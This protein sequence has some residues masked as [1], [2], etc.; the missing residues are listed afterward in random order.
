MIL[1]VK[2][3]FTKPLFFNRTLINIKATFSQE[4]RFELIFGGGLM[5]LICVFLCEFAGEI[6]G[7]A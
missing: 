3:A 7:I 4:L 6:W 5:V 1:H 2:L